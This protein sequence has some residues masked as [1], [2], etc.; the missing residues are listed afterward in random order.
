MVDFSKLY[1][2]HH[3]AKPVT[4]SNCFLKA[5]FG[6][7]SVRAE[8]WRKPTEAASREEAP[9]RVPEEKTSE[10]PAG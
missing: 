7:E 10:V 8:N 3:R 5:I 6:N 9:L 1:G 4:R 2:A